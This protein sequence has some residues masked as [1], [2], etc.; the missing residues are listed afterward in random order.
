MT[1]TLSLLLG[2]S[3][4][5]GLHTAALAQ[6]TITDEVT[7]TQETTTTGDL[8]VDGAGLISPASGTGIVVNSSNTVVVDGAIDINDA[9][10]VTGIEV[11]ADDNV[12]SV[13]LNGQIRLT[14][15]FTPEDT[16]GDNLADGGFAQGSGKTGILISGANTFT[17]N[18]R[19]NSTSII[20]VEGNDSA[21]I[22]LASGAT[23]QGN[24]SVG[25]A[26]R[27]TGR[28][29][30]GVDVAGNVNDV[31]T[32]GIITAQ[33]QGAQAV[34]ISGDL[35]GGYSS[36]G[37]ISNTGYRFTSRPSLSIRDRLGD[38]DRFQ[39]GSAVQ[40]SGNIAE[41]I[42]FRQVFE[43]VVDSDGTPQLDDDGNVL[44]RLTARSSVTQFGSAPAILV[45]GDGTPIAIGVVAEITDASAVDF[46]ES[47]QFAF[48]NQGE[49]SAQGVYNDVGA[50]AFEVRNATLSGGI[51]NTGLMQAFAFRSG[52]DGTADA[53][54]ATGRA[55]VIVLGDNAIAER[56]QNSGIIAATVSE[57]AQQVFADRNAIIPARALDVVAIDIAAT[58]ELAA[59]NNAGAIS[60]ILSG[61]EGTAVVVRDASGTLSRIDN[62]GTITAIG[63]QSDSSGRIENTASLIALDLSN[64][65]VG[66]TITQDAPTEDI[67]L[68]AAIEG[69][70]L[71]GSGDDVID[72]RAGRVLGAVAFGAGEDRFDIADASYEGRITDTDG[73]LVLNVAN[74]SVQL[75]GGVPVNVAS[76]SFDGA[77][78]FRPTI[79]GQAG[80]A[81]TLV[82]SDS[83]S[84]GD[85]ARIIPVI[86][87]FVGETLSRFAIAMGP[88]V[89]VAGDLGTLGEGFSPFVYNTEYSIDPTT[90]TLF[91]DLRLRGAGELGLDPVQ[92][93]ALP[94]TFEA[95]AANPALAGS[96]LNITNGEVFNAAFNQLLPEFAAASRQFILAN[97]DGAVGA[98][99]S[100]LDAAR[101]GQ[102]KPGGFWFQE[103]A[104]F[105]DRERAQL[106][107]QYRGSG[108]GF[109]GGLDTELGPFHAV[110]FNLG[111]A[112][113]E[114]EDTVGL[115]DPL[116]IVTLQGG[117][118]AGYQRGAFSLDAYA[119][120]GLN[121]FDS[122]RNVQ[123]GD[124]VGL[125]Q[126]EWD[127]THYNA[128]LRG[129]YDIPLGNRF[130]ARPT[131]S[132]DYL[133]L[134][135]DAYTEQGTNGIAF[136]IDERTVDTAAVTAMLNL[137]AEF[138]G[139]RTWVR[140][141]IRA[142]Y[143]QESIGDVITSG[144]FVDGT[145]PF[146]IL[147]EEFPDS[148]FL[149]GLSV[150]AGSNYSSFGFD[151][152][153]DIRDG[154]IR[155]TG[156]VVVRVLF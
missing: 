40:I 81:A 33:G 84:F 55:R 29:S 54:S 12:G 50:T 60:A 48:I 36:A 59:I 146:A 129:G 42:F 30:V 52:D 117:L 121:T 127:G 4:L 142:G 44:Q 9:N 151:L 57:D 31:A 100:Q 18:I 109:S 89:S 140:P 112:S 118:Y 105:A 114:V 154:F 101:Q 21:G 85:G 102:A 137:G 11:Q 13:T 99:G 130:F 82:A 51:S 111:F 125:S 79:D 80:T 104:Y 113:T 34:S 61:R 37:T 43:D 16:D 28:N 76:A 98:V 139:K 90:G 74:A 119:G 27:I 1:R 106:S 70:I 20:Q 132:V 116:D 3:A 83:V 135:E 24:L 77:S 124:F 6:T 143:R 128:S 95:F 126:A 133:S 156:R 10:D 15:D 19:T 131:L 147:A 103:F 107:E 122:N 65:T 152:D 14:E 110:G 66:V 75:D 73:T 2:A 47:L 96:I 136:A 78:T 53:N 35:E 145:T 67:V 17:G 108:F 32:N 49:L 8:T 7:T 141:M 93:A 120:G 97:A 63:L 94:A 39:A 92:T 155:T 91:V 62:T 58:A 87:T 150:A 45:A 22:R 69:D 134:T 138:N 72:V 123:I 68:E 41:G 149:V 26:M 25:G 144:R 46:D 86:D 88:N 115:D 148:G 38:D 23:V 5:V 64:N 153:T 56:L 71:L